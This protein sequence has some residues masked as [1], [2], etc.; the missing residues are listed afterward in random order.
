MIAGTTA[1]VCLDEQRQGRRGTG[2][3][4]DRAAWLLR[5][6]GDTGGGT[7]TW[8]SPL[9]WAEQTRPF[10]EDRWWPLLLPLAAFAVTSPCPAGCWSA[11]TSVAA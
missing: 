1:V 4:R 2:R 10:W 7:L 8:F 11:G 9:G 3:D 5:A 6:I